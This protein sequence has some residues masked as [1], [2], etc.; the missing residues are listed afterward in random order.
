MIDAG[1]FMASKGLSFD[2]WLEA[3]RSGVTATQVAKAGSGLAGL[4][5]LVCANPK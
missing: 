5:V 2:G 1:R 3:R 4:G